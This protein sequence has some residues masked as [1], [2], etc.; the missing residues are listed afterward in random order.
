MKGVPG[1]QLKIFANSVTFKDGSR[2]GRV[3]IDQVHLDK[4][5]MAPPSGT[6]FMPPA[7]TVQP[8]G[9]HFN[10]PAQITIPNDGM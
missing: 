7:W 9:T 10:P 5:P 6:F 2:T 8:A 3:S 4:V 1:L